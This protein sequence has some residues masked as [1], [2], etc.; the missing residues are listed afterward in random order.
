MATAA[1]S[2][3]TEVMQR[4]CTEDGPSI[5]YNIIRG[6]MQAYC[7]EDGL[8]LVA[9]SHGQA[10]KRDMQPIDVLAEVLVRLVA[11]A[12]EAIEIQPGRVQLKPLA[13]AI[14]NSILA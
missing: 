6:K 4:C 10:A 5:R 2:R 12:E 9:V 1:L 7:T 8:L 11:L 14:R 13:L 3:L